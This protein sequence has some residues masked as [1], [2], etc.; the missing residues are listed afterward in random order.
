VL[1]FILALILLR[2]VNLIRTAVAFALS[3]VVALGLYAARYGLRE[4]RWL[5]QIRPNRGM[6]LV[7]WVIGTIVLAIVL[8]VASATLNRVWSGAELT[9]PQKLVFY[10]LL[11]L[12][13]ASLAASLAL[14]IVLIYLGRLDERV[15]QPIFMHMNRLS[16]LILEAAGERLNVKDWEIRGVKRLSDGGLSIW[17]RPKVAAL[18]ETNPTG[19][20]KLVNNRTHSSWLIEADRWGRI[21]SILPGDGASS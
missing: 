7:H 17:A 9:I 15:P 21:R 16:D 19:G 2:P 20:G 12:T 13:C 6:S 5:Y 4:S 11:S 18:V 10:V 1:I 8:G 3:A 14:S